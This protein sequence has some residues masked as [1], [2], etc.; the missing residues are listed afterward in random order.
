MTKSQRG[1]LVSFVIKRNTPEDAKKLKDLVGYQPIK[2]EHFF[3]ANDIAS[4]Q[5]IHD[6]EGGNLP[7]INY[8]AS[9]LFEAGRITGIREERSRKRGA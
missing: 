8:L 5:A 9:I 7:D 2:E 4:L 1:V 6:L 3:L